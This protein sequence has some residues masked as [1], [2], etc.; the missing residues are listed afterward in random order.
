MQAQALAG[1]VQSRVTARTS[2]VAD[3]PRGLAGGSVLVS[4]AVPMLHAVTE[5]WASV[6]G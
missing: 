5:V 2:A 6:H 4:D 1:I 3:T